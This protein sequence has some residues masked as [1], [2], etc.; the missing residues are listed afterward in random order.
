MRSPRCRG[1]IATRMSRGQMAQPTSHRALNLDRD[2]QKKPMK[3]SVRQPKLMAVTWASM[4]AAV[5][6]GASCPAVP[7]DSNVAVTSPMNRHSSS[8][9]ASAPSSSCNRPCGISPTLRGAE[10]ARNS[11]GVSTRGAATAVT[12][13]RIVSTDHRSA[14]AGYQPPAR[15]LNPVTIAIVPMAISQTW[16]ALLKHSN[17]RM[18]RPTPFIRGTPRRYLPD[19]GTPLRY[20]P[21]ASPPGAH[22]AAR[23]IAWPRRLHAV[24]RPQRNDM[25]QRQHRGSMRRPWI[26]RRTTDSLSTSSGPAQAMAPRAHDPD[27]IGDAFQIRDDMGREQYGAAALG[28]DFDHL[29]QE[30]PPRDRIQARHGLIQHQQFRLVPQ[31]RQG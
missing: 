8:C 15:A 24:R 4:A 13:P 30:P 1:A 7:T 22:A 5:A 27:L 28:G 18:V 2:V 21:G 26:V 12:S 10:M 11:S 6:P 17:C 14:A 23:S 9:E 25:R 3:C 19:P 16:N 31:C 20:P 29:L